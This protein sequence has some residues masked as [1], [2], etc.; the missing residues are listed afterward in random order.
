MPSRSVFASA[1]CGGAGGAFVW[2]VTSRGHVDRRGL[3]LPGST[4]SPPSFAAA[5]C[6]TLPSRTT[7][8]NRT[9]AARSPSGSRKAR[10]KASA[11]SRTSARARTCDGGCGASDRAGVHAPR[12]RVRRVELMPCAIVFRVDVDRVAVRVD[13]GSRI[14]ELDVFV[15][16]QRPRGE[17]VAVE[18]RAEPM[19]ACQNIWGPWSRAR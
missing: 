10:N 12:C 8:A 1:R 18:L 9:A 2:G 4:G 11:G 3:P 16:H 5:P 14:L 6:S 7:S 19:T 15:A 13:G 17:E